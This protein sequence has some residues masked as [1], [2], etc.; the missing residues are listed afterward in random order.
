VCCWTGLDADA[1]GVGEDGEEGGKTGLFILF[2]LSS[3]VPEA[4]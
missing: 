1:D 2:P 4:L 3:D